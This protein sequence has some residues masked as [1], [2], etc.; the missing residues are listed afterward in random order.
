MGTYI[1]WCWTSHLPMQSRAAEQ[2][3]GWE[4]AVPFCPCVKGPG[5]T[6][7]LQGPAQCTAGLQNGRRLNQSA[8]T[9]PG[10]RRACGERGCCDSKPDWRGA[11]AAGGLRQ[12]QTAA[13]SRCAPHV[14]ASLSFYTRGT[15]PLPAQALTGPGPARWASGRRCQEAARPPSPGHA[16]RLALW[17][18]TGAA[19]AAITWEDVRSEVR[20]EVRHLRLRGARTVRAAQARWVRVVT[21][22]PR[23]QSAVP[24]PSM[25]A[26]PRPPEQVP[27]CRR[28][29]PCSPP[30]HATVHGSPRAQV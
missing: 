17:C 20:S 28:A 1:P 12:A 4:R 5:D 2:R 29:A 19:A 15:W 24:D 27:R 25:P 11:H 30:G 9:P 3:D 16:G 26:R 7:H 8:V 6:Y 23:A 10:G 14:M 18:A 21:F 22:P 13:R